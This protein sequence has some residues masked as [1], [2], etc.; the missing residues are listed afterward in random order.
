MSS[1]PDT[2]PPSVTCTRCGQD[3]VFIVVP[4]TTDNPW[5]WFR[6]DRCSYVFTPPSEGV[7]PTA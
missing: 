1:T 7:I 2:I 5:N 4:M 3:R 6:C